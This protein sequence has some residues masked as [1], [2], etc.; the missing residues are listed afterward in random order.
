LI[1]TPTGTSV[2]SRKLPTFHFTLIT[3]TGTTQLKFP[4]H[5]YQPS[6]NT[7]GDWYV[8]KTIKGTTSNRTSQE[9]TSHQ[10]NEEQN[11]PITAPI[12]IHMVRL[13]QSTSSTDE[14]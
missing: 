7:K 3:S 14:D 8:S 11:A 9:T 5:G 12:T 2:G 6:R 10:N 1:E 4:K 13:N